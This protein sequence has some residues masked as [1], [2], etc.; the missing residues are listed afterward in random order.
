MKPDHLLLRHV[1]RHL[2][3]YAAEAEAAHDIA[4]AVQLRALRSTV[5]QFL[6]TDR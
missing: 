2:A 1:A 3:I 4:A 6:E 5:M